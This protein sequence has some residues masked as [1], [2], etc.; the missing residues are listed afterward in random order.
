MI[1]A[2]KALRCDTLLPRL[3]VSP[4]RWA[5]RS[6]SPT[7]PRPPR[8]RAPRRRRAPPAGSCSS[9]RAR[10]TRFSIRTSP[11]SSSTTATTNRRSGYS[12]YVPSRLFG[13]RH[14]DVPRLV[15]ASRHRAV[16][17]RRARS[18]AFRDADG[19][20]RLTLAISESSSPFFSLWAPRAFSFR[21]KRA[22]PFAH[23][24]LTNHSQL[25]FL[26]PDRRSDRRDL[27]PG[28]RHAAGVQQRGACTS[29]LS[30]RVGRLQSTGFASSRRYK[31]RSSNT[32]K[33]RASDENREK[34]FGVS[35]AAWA[36]GED[37]PGVAGR[38]G[39]GA[40]ER[41]RPRARPR[42]TRDATTTT[43]TRTAI[44]ARPSARVQGGRAGH[45]DGR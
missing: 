29:A 22:P 5:R 45:E 40:S 24:R 6:R 23:L 25:P 32:H 7:L 35:F 33:R 1:Y 16:P 19:A 12:T 30:A 18:R 36:N 9:S 43:T 20:P 28:L 11:R 41:R 34:V 2:R 13:Q 17:R 44:T 37:H 4:P 26:V 42:R 14:A 39:R 3:G 31:T 21:R 8:A 38:H 15:V 10:R 27:V